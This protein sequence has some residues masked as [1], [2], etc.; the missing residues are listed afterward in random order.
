MNQT[1]ARFFKFALLVTGKGEERD[2]FLPRLFRSLMA[3][4]N[5][6]FQIGRRISQRGPITSKKKK[7]QQKVT[8]VADTIPS[9]IPNK[10]ADTIG[11]P[12]RAYFNQGF[13]Y[14]ILIDDL[15]ADRGPHANLVFQRYRNALDT[16]LSP[17]GKE[18]CASVHFLVNMVEAYYFADASA[19][20][21][22][23]GTTLQD[24]QGDVEEIRHPKNDLKAIRPGFREIEH[25][26]QIMRRLD[27]EH[28]LSNPQTCRSLRALFGWCAK[29]I[30]RPFDDTYQ[31]RNGE[32]WDVTR[33]Q[34]DWLPG[35]SSITPS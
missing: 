30:G 15:E 6:S 9:K 13:D 10:D 31:L 12:A 24:H 7:N 14:V 2:Q 3:D 22:V 20:N 29:A 28:V 8:G 33:G 4:G 27:M 23:C 26:M 21:E 32:Y 35:S 17:L 16:F 18:N 25:G 11:I 34:I 19:I 1:P 5:C